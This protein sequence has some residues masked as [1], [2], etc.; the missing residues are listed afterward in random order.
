MTD[1]RYFSVIDFH[2]ASFSISAQE[3]FEDVFAFTWEEQKMT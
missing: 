2:A 1:V 3:D